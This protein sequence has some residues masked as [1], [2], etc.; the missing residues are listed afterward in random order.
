LQLRA[1][2]LEQLGN[3]IRQLEAGPV[4]VLVLELELVLVLEQQAN[5]IRQLVV[6]GGVLGQKL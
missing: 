6:F 2:G 5:Q 1:L 4:L 3:Q